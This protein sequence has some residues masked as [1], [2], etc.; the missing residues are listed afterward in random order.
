[1]LRRDLARC[2]KWAWEAA[3][4]KQILEAVALHGLRRH[5]GRLA[6]YVHAAGK[7]SIGFPLITVGRAVFIQ[8]ASASGSSHHSHILPSAH[9]GYGTSSAAREVEC[10]LQDLHGFHDEFGHVSLWTACTRQ[11]RVQLAR[12]QS[13]PLASAA[14][15][16][17]SSVCKSTVE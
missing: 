15:Q 5:I 1:M 11:W 6:F 4:Q 3:N 13:M 8:T 10:A 2:S 14:L 7:S 17:D 12:F 9:A 16:R